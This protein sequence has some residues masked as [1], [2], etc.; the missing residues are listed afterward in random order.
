MSMIFRSNGSIPTLERVRREESNHSIGSHSQ[1]SSG[2]VGKKR[3]KC[4]CVGARHLLWIYRRY[5]SHWLG[6]LKYV[7]IYRIHSAGLHQITLHCNA[8]QY[9]TLQSKRESISSN[10]NIYELI[11][12][13]TIHFYFLLC[14]FNSYLKTISSHQ[15]STNFCTDNISESFVDPKIVLDSIKSS[16]WKFFNFWVAGGDEDRSYVYCKLCFESVTLQLFLKIWAMPII[17]ISS[18]FCF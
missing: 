16:S 15:S 18:S 14:S 17:V 13:I 9:I 4:F 6:R 7:A 11:S 3:T 12:S 2:Q 1:T 5:L 10:N 8:L